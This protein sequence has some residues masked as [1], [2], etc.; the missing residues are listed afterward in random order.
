[1]QD[2]TILG[3]RRGTVKLLSHSTLWETYA[4]EAINDL[5]RILGVFAV[6]IQHVGS[7]SIKSIKAK[8][9]I[10]IIVGVEELNGVNSFIEKLAQ[11]NYFHR[12]FKE[13]DVLFIKGDMSEEIRTHH[14]HIVKHNSDRWNDQINFRDY[15]NHHTEEAKKYEKLKIHLEKSNRSNRRNYTEQKGIYIIEII[16]KAKE[17]KNNLRS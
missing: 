1:M 8:P 16:D 6:D 7:T 9:I 2:I 3:L 17:W 12:P 13:D 15:L 5:K 4:N 14:I 10:D 11:N